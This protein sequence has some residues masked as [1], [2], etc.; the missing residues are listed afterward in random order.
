V[1]LEKALHCVKTQEG[2]WVAENPSISHF[3]AREGLWLCWRDVGDGRG[4]LAGE[5]TGI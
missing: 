4:H 2:G 3:D 1:G 5:E